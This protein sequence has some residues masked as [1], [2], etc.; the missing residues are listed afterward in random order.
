MDP[1]NTP[2]LKTSRSPRNS[3]DGPEPIRYSAEEIESPIRS[4]ASVVSV[5]TDGKKPKPRGKWRHALGIFFLLCTVVLWTVSN[6][7]ASVRIS[8]P[9]SLYKPTTACYTSTSLPIPY[10]SL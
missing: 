9:F 6:F 4:P 5:W 8:F 1:H 2:L 10:H 7:L 3:E